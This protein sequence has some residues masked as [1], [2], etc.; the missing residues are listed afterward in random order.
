MGITVALAI[1]G[2]PVLHAQALDV[3][4][5]DVSSNPIAY[6]GKTLRVTAEII[7]WSDG[8]SLYDSRCPGNYGIEP[9]I[10][11]SDEDGARI[12]KE[13][14]SK[15]RTKDGVT[16]VEATFFGTIVPAA[17]SPQGTIK[18]FGM[19]I[20]DIKSI[21]QV[22]DK[23]SWPFETK[24]KPSARLRNCDSHSKGNRSQKS[25][26][27]RAFYFR[28]LASREANLTRVRWGHL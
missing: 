13:L 5:C 8:G 10:K 22:P 16:R 24:N 14:L 9:L 4:Y 18:R 20:Q 1:F 6:M 7:S 19:S 21:K 3:D 11:L 28:Q 15:S 17:Q 27:P 25:S 23:N 2:T 12:M 26:H